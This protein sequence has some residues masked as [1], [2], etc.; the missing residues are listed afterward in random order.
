MMNADGKKLVCHE[1]W[2]GN[3]RADELIEF[4]KFRGRLLSLPYRAVEGG[5]IHFLSLCDQQT[6]A[7]I[8]VADVAGHGEIVSNI[9]L[10]LKNLLRDNLNE[11]DNSKLLMS[12]NDALRHRLK[13]GKFVT[14]VAATFNGE[15]GKF[16]YAY[17]GH[18]TVLRYDAATAHW[19]PLRPVETRNSGAPLGVI[20]DTEYVQAMARIGRGDMLLFY[21]DG[22]LDVKQGNGERLHLAELLEICRKVTS[23]SPDPGKILG[24]LVDH[25][26]NLGADGF[27]DDVT[28]LIVEV[29]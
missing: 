12:L 20:G 5:D 9:A 29:T 14:M 1:I 16:I 13:Q 7:K 8:V 28:S 3:H 24:S 26:E 11:I 23:H 15:D 22:L 10:E 17:A 25:I 27:G 2:G 18:P 19:Q 4:G 21:T 6:L